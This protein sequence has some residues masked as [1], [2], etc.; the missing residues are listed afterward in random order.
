MWQ[1]V[2]G[3]ALVKVRKRTAGVCDKWKC[4][5][6]KVEKYLWKFHQSG[7]S[8]LLVDAVHTIRPK[9]TYC[10]HANAT[11]LDI[12]RRLTKFPFNFQHLPFRHCTKK[13]ES[14]SSWNSLCK[15][16]IQIFAWGISQLLHNMGKHWLIGNPECQ[17][18]YMLDDDRQSSP[19]C[20]NRWRWRWQSPRRYRRL[21][22]C[23]LEGIVRLKKMF[24][25]TFPWKIFPSHGLTFTTPG[26]LCLWHVAKRSN[27]PEFFN[28][29][30]Q[31]EDN[32][33]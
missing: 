19:P 33:N 25:P 23:S 29:E 12:L 4:G 28:W 24:C 9:G 5:L 16:G 31:A 18:R 8:G 27:F 20:H 1:L 22:L 3:K 21:Q 14:Y 10:L 11:K 2:Q 26:I 30:N 15:M 7:W 6:E 17:G 32:T 13:L